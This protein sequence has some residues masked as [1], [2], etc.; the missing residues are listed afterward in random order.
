ME[1]I[2][3]IGLGLFGRR[4][5]RL[6]AGAGADVIAIDRQQDLIERMR[7]EVSLAICMDATNEHALRANGIDQVDVA[8]VGIG[9]SFEDAALAVAQSADAADD[10]GSHHA[11]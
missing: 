5:A 3:I 4:L 1:R 10:S 9:N 11:G 2:A 7:D 6:L 8:V